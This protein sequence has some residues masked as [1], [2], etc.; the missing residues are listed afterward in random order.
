MFKPYLK[1][2]VRNGG[3]GQMGVGIE[4]FR[5]DAIDSGE[6]LTDGEAE[7]IEESPSISSTAIMRVYEEIGEDFWSGGGITAKK[8]S[9]EL[10]AFGDIKR[11]NIHINCLGGDCFTAQA[12]HSIISDHNSK[13]TAYIDGVAASAA[14]VIA[15]AA[16]EVV[17]RHNTS[18]MIHHPWAVCMGNA[19]TLRKGAEDLE[20]LTIPIVSVYK[21]QVKGKISEDEIRQLMDD[22]T[23][24]TADEA[25]DN[26][27]VDR[28]RGKIKAIAKA[29]K[30][31]IMCSGKLMDVARYH[32]KNVPKYPTMKAEKPEESPAK[33]TNKGKSMTREDIDPQLL[34]Q[35]EEAARVGE[36]SRLAALDAMS[37]PGLS[38][39]ITKAKAENKQPGEIAMECLTVTRAQLKAAEDTSALARDAAPANKVKAG[40]APL[41][42]PE[43]PVNRGAGLIAKAFKAQA[44][45]QPVGATN[46]N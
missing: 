33:P 2:I 1:A 16:D 46:G 14:T 40:D 23:W 21:S 19:E 25:R 29:S 9:D 13:T 36:R 41:G 20:K 34:T 28:V 31:Q 30:T 10:Q 43:H 45:K 38:E 37:G 26:G 3:R 6:D 8:F 4:L 24:M 39:I 42:A 11:L 35:I 17:A 15:C 12:I 27:F 44:P 32:Y 5:M 22:E 18:Y 7:A